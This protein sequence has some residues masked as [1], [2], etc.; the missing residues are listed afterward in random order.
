MRKTRYGMAAMAA[1]AALVLSACGGGGGSEGGGGGEASG[2]TG[3]GEKV[4][5][6]IKYDQPGLGFSSS[7]K[8]SGFDV[9]VATY[10]AKELGYSADQIDFVESPSANRENMLANKQVDMIFATYSITD[11][12]KKTV[13]FAGPYFVAG[14]DLLVRA[15][16]NS[17]TG[18]DSLNGKNLCSVTGSTSAQ[19]IKDEHASSVN[20]VERPSYAECVT[21]MQGG[22]IDAVT[23][24]DII[25]AGLAAQ[26]NNAGKY[27]VVGKP[28]SE[29][30]YGVG[31]PKG[32]DKCADIN[33]A[34]NKM[35]DD[36]SWEA[37]LKKNTE[38]VDYT[39]NKKLNPPKPGNSCA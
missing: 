10:V 36:G 14:Q 31:L 13:D 2:G 20:L 7:G 24:D 1:G 17:I 28:F 5:I 8:F 29:E 27:K 4:R 30:K 39:Y 16:D 38:G 6:G 34:I 37:A 22:Q 11:E 21:A 25:L 19:R 35:V 26:P 15:D 33:A 9:D 3:G 12:R 18:P 32:T 23:T